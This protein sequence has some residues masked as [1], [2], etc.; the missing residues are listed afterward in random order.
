LKSINRRF[1]VAP[2]L[3]CT[4]RHDRYLLR[5]ISRHAV[6]YSEMVTTGALLFGDQ[7]SSAVW[8]FRRLFNEVT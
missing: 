1:C 7:A 5:L 3:D 4:D 2:M 8:R 6:L